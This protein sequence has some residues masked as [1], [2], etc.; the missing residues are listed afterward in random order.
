[1]NRLG[2]DEE[3]E[4][5]KLYLLRTLERYRGDQTP[6]V[7]DRLEGIAQVHGDKL[8]LADGGMRDAH[9]LCP[10]NPQEGFWGTCRPLETGKTARG[11]KQG[12]G[13]R[14]DGKRL[15]EKC[16]QSHNQG[17]GQRLT[18][19]SPDAPETGHREHVQG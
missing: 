2:S 1:M 16:E 3:Q 14:P 5:I 19:S 4:S 13:A 10:F 18:T 6:N 8:C 15:L 17:Q 12:L 7:L 9:E 11:E